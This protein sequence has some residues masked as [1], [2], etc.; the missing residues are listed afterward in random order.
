MN[1]WT[2]TTTDSTVISCDDEQIFK[3]L[4]EAQPSSSTSSWQFSQSAQTFSSKV[5]T[6]TSSAVPGC[7]H[8]H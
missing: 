4:A 8:S 2:P 6:A 1:G 5:E 3:R 7:S